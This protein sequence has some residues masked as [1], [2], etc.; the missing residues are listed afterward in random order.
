MLIM[1]FYFGLEFDKP[2]AVKYCF[3]VIELTDSK[4]CS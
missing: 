3:I 2:P 4:L 1:Y